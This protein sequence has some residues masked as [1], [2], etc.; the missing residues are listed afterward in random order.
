MAAICCLSIGVTCVAVIL[1]VVFGYASV[2]G[3]RQIG[4]HYLGFICFGMVLGL[5]TSLPV[6]TI[7][8]VVSE[9]NALLAVILGSLGTGTICGLVVRLICW[10][11]LH[12]T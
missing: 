10:S 12:I 5:L 6:M 11:F 4:D 9:R 7:A 2:W 8:L 1:S 3:W